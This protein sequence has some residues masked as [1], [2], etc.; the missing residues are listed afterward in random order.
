[1]STSRVAV[2]T[3][4]NKGIGF[5]IVKELC[6]KFDGIVYLTSRDESR[7]RDAVKKLNELGL[8]PHFHQLDVDDESSITRLCEHLKST[9]G[10]LDILVN[11]AAIAFKAA[12]TEPFGL[13]ATETLRTNFFSN[14]KLCQV[15]F[16][17]LRPHARVVNVS[18][19][20]GFL[21]KV[22]GEEPAS[23]ELRKKLSSPDLTVDELCSLMQGF[24]DAAQHGTHGKLGWQ[25]SAYSVSKVGFSA[26]TRIQHMAFT[27]DPREDIVINHVHPGYVDTDMTSHK[28]PLTIE[29]GAMA[30]SWLA[31]LPENVEEPK[32]AYVWFDKRIIDWVNGPT[33]SPV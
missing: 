26:L 3:G 12:A 22:C 17:I 24:I 14:L 23:G 28:G 11:N 6:Q 30:P 25:N 19:S 27:K 31:L 29:Q 33:P 32:G 10:G 18:S 4:S 1:M 2:V 13:Q 7:G 5:A 16:P 9:Y 8:K 20:V 21:G 15:L